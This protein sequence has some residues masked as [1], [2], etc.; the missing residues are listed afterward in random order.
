MV[1]IKPWVVVAPGEKQKVEDII[2]EELPEKKRPKHRCSQ[3]IR[4]CSL[5]ILTKFLDTHQIRYKVLVQQ[6]GHMVVTLP[7][8]LHEGYS[9]NHTGAEAI[10]FQFLDEEIDDIDLSGYTQCKSPSCPEHSVGLEVFDPLQDTPST[11]C[12]IPKFAHLSSDPAA[13]FI[14]DNWTER[15]RNTLPKSAYDPKYVLNILFTRYRR[16]NKT[17]GSMEHFLDTP[18]YV[19]CTRKSRESRAPSGSIA[20]S[21]GPRIQKG[22]DAEQQADNG[23]I[24]IEVARLT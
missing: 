4:H 6:P 18:D 21:E 22:M 3:W 7:N 17:D 5:W 9:W 24:D 23:A 2:W 8:T 20:S 12:R 15:V 19:L 16:V 14:L 13:E 11:W 1:G 10:N